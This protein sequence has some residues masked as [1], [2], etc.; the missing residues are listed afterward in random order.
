[1]R[2][3]AVNILDSCNLIHAPFMTPFVASEKHHGIVKAL[4]F[5]DSKSVYEA[6]AFHIIPGDAVDSISFRGLP[7]VEIA[8]EGLSKTKILH[9]LPDVNFECLEDMIRT[10]DTVLAD[11]AVAR[12]VEVR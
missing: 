2:D 11:L 4:N 10:S 12:V 7:I 3:F 8:C 1:M 6:A 5:L 9:I